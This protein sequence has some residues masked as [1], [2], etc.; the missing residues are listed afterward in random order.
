VS[1]G[2]TGSEKGRKERE[3]ERNFEERKRSLLLQF[4]RNIYKV[5][6][7]ELFTVW[8]AIFHVILNKYKNKYRNTYQE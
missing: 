8:R 4:D 7:R 5:K 2:A 6:F 1:E 3:R